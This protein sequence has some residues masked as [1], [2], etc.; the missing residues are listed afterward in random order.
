MKIQK[1]SSTFAVYGTTDFAPYYVPSRLSITKE[2]KQNKKENFCGGEDVSD[3][4]AKNR[5]IHAA[6]WL[7]QTEVDAF[8]DLVDSDDP[9]EAIT[10]AWSGEVRVE[11]GE[12]EGPRALDPVTKDWLYQYSVDLVSTGRDEPGHNSGDY[13][14]ISSGMAGDYNG[15]AWGL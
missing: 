12:I 2:R 11:G 14:I 9:F 7:R 4:G 1:S 3:L 10:P 6:G 5:T 13:G 15:P 8:N